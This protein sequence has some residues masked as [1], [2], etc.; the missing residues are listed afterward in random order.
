VQILVRASLV[1][2]KASSVYGLLGSH[3]FGQVWQK[4][5]LLI[6]GRI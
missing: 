2:Y 1:G 5:L 6:V 3:G 4:Y